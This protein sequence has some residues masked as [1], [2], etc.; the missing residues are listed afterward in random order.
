MDEQ[1]QERSLYLRLGPL[2]VASGGGSSIRT[3]AFILSLY[4][5]L[6][7]Q[8]KTALSIIKSTLP[9]GNC[10]PLSNRPTHTASC[11]LVTI[12]K[13]SPPFRTSHPPHLAKI[14]R[15]WEISSTLEFEIFV[16]LPQRIR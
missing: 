2:L 7:T 9:S 6:K 5:S 1:T 16:T 10:K 4:S 15:S 8:I 12:D 14:K 13:Q 3:A 11:F